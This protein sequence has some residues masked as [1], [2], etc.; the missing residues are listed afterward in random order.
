M[1]TFHEP[2]YTLS[3]NETTGT[4]NLSLPETLLKLACTC[5]NCTMQTEGI[6][7]EYTLAGGDLGPFHVSHDGDITLDESLDYERKDLYNFTISCF[8]VIDKMRNVRIN[9][10]AIIVVRVKPLNEFIPTF[11]GSTSIT[12]TVPF[13]AAIGSVIL[14]TLPGSATETYGPAIDMDNGV[15]GDV[16]YSLEPAPGE[17]RELI[18][19]F[20]VLNETVGVVIV[21]RTLSEMMYMLRIRACDGNRPQ[22][23][24]PFITVRVVVENNNHTVKSIIPS[25]T[26]THNNFDI[27]TMASFS[28]NISFLRR[29]PFMRTLNSVTLRYTASDSMPTTKSEVF[30]FFTT[31]NILLMTISGGILA[32]VLAIATVVCSIL[33]CNNCCK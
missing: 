14:S 19:M 13:D 21:N 27:Y 29:S 28:S 11:M 3:I 18:D 4:D 17:K 31:S 24:C 8:K 26:P 10:T 23:E 7:I 25:A 30:S 2:F 20:L 1:L 5:Q 16:R 32:A 22:I 12:V 9:G 15:D 33:Y 6:P